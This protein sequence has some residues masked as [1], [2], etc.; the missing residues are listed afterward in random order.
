MT[1]KNLITASLWS[2]AGTAFSRL[3]FLG[4]MLWIGSEM[5]PASFGVLGIILVSTNV[6]SLVTVSS[7]GL[8][9]RRFIGAYL[10][11][12][13]SLANSIIVNFILL[14]VAVTSACL[15]IL[16][17]DPMAVSQL[18]FGSALQSVLI[19]MTGSVFF[20]ANM[21]NVLEGCLIGFQLVRAVSLIKVVESFAFLFALGFFIQLKF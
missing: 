3:C 4:A 7:L 14:S 13:P 20:I 5:S 19:P 18:L 6:F 17:I 12:D 9:L 10:V 16:L 11:S 2:L 8:C 15:M 21:K 1:E